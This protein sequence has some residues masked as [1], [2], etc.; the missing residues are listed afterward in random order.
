MMKMPMFE[1]EAIVALGKIGDARAIEP[2]ILVLKN[3]NEDVQE[4]AKAAL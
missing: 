3:K 2:L 1:G 4:A